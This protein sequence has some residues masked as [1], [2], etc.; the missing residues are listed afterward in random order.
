MKKLLYPIIGFVIL[1][2]S[3]FNTNKKTEEKRI[4]EQN[5]DKLILRPFQ[6]FGLLWSCSSGNSDE[7]DYVAPDPTHYSELIDSI[8]DS[9]TH[10]SHY[11]GT[12]Y[13]HSS[14][15][16]SSHYSG[17][18]QSHQSHSSHSSHYSAR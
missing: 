5:S 13:S 12:H 7:D 17:T 16:H 8:T 9:G 6:V 14:Q 18:H 3:V 10:S 2:L 15:N 11:S 4:E 1:C